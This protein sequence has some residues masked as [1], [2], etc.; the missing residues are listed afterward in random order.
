M[1]DDGPDPFTNMFEAPAKLARALFAPLTEATTGTALKPEDMQHWAEVGTKL[2]GMWLEYQTEQLG[3]P[4]AFAAYFDPA[5]WMRMADD[6][7]RQMPLADPAR[8][9]AL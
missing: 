6:W 7:Y 4:Q 8:Q 1:T 2:Q 9:Q 5:R 3:D